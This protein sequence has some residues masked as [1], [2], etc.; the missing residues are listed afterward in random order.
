MNRAGS[1]ELKAFIADTSAFYYYRRNKASAALQCVNKAMRTHTR[2]REWA[3]VAK[4]HLHT[5]TILAKLQKHDESVRCM[6]QVLGMVL[7]SQLKP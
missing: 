1:M 2:R 7:R 4:C 3:H 6:G 5:G